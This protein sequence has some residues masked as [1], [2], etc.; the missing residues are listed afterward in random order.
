[1]PQCQ[2]DRNHWAAR[3]SWENT[4]L[5]PQD[6]EINN[7]LWLLPTA[8]SLCASSQDLLRIYNKEVQSH[9]YFKHTF[10]NNAIYLNMHVS[11]ILALD[12]FEYQKKKL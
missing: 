5:V 10:K 8:L 1:M 6:T 2:V 4:S 3:G 7:L 11:E 9:P 12:P